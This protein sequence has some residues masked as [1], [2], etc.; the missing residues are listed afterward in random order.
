MADRIKLLIQ[1]RT[2][3]KSQIT[4]LT[5]QV[6]R[7]RYDKGALRL[8]MARITDLYHAYEE[9]NDELVVLDPND[10]HKDEF[11]NVQER[12]YSLASKVEEIINSN[13]SAAITSATNSAALPNGTAT[14]IV[15]RRVKLPE[16]TLP[17]FDGQYENWLSFKNT[18]IAMIDSQ[19]DLSDVE[20][21]QYLRSALTGEAAN[22]IRFLIK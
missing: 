15:K 14:T 3:L 4:G 21:L 16:A 20:K 5:N 7:D 2:S 19:T 13:V 17:K 12:F 22:K 18:F 9:F 1:K 6:E 11:T 8:R 10:A